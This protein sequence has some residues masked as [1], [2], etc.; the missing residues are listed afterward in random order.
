MYNLNTVEGKEARIKEI[1]H[2][3][4]KVMTTPG[5][6]INYL[7]ATAI[8]NYLNEIKKDLERQIR[9]SYKK[10]NIKKLSKEEIDTLNIMIRETLDEYYRLHD[11]DNFFRIDEI[12]KVC[13]KQKLTVREIPA[14]VEMTNVIVMG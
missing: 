13:N 7:E 2:L 11:A 3:V 5:N 12:L 6:Y 4:S 8:V 14:L 1:E 10:D 9:E